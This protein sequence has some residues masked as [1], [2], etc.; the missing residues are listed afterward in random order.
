MPGYWRKEMAMF[1]LGIQFGFGIAVAVIAVEIAKYVSQAVYSRYL[2][3]RI[4]A[5]IKKKFPK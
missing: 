5:L 4:K 1:S 2:A 3:H